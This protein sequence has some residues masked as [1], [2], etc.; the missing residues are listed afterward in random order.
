MNVSELSG[1]DTFW[2]IAQPYLSIDP[3]NNTHQLSA[4]QRILEIGA[5][6]GERFFAVYAD[7]AQ[8]VLVASAIYVD[9]K[10]LFLAVMPPEAAHALAA[11]LRAKA[12]KLTG[13]MGRRDLLSAFTDAYATPSTV[14]V[15]LMLYQ[16]MK[17][18]EAGRAT[19]TARTA[20]PEDLE[21]LVASE[22]VEERA[23]M[24]RARR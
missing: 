15:N 3:A 14:H 5:R 13:V 9:S 12:V 8:D 24:K 20:T 23:A 18:P 6:Y 2:Q 16:L 19:G 4:A 17:A 7:D 22:V 1:I 10:A 11:H 21:L